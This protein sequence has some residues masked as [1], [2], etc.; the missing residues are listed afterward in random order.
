MTDQQAFYVIPTDEEYWGDST[1][2]D[3]ARLAADALECVLK[4]GARIMGI[5]L[6]V[7]QAAGGDALRTH[8]AGTRSQ[9]FI[10]SL[11]DFAWQHDAVQGAAY[12]GDNID[13]ASVLRDYDR[14]VVVCGGASRDVLAHATP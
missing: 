12:V 11:A 2:C 13:S 9:R 7:T 3:E 10:D 6:R 14:H 4:L 1:T 8:C 5:D